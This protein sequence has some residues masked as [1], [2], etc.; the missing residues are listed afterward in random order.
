MVLVDASVS[1]SSSDYPSGFD[2]DVKPPQES[3]DIDIGSLPRPMPIFGPLFGFNN[4]HLARAIRVSI[5]RQFGPLHRMPTPDEAN[6]VAYHTA[7]GQA[8][9]S[10]GAPLGL[11]AGAYRTWATRASYKFPFVKAKE[12]FDANYM[13]WRGIVLAHGQRARFL[14]HSARFGAYGIIGLYVVKTAFLGFAASVA[15][16]GTLS[17]PRLADVVQALSTDRKAKLERE[18]V[19][20]GQQDPTGQGPTNASDLWKKHR[21][22]IGAPEVD[23]GGPTAGQGDFAESQATEAKMYGDD[24]NMGNGQQD[25]APVAQKASRPRRGPAWNRATTTPDPNT[26]SSPSDGFYGEY[27][28]AS[29]TASNESV[30]GAKTSSWEQLR[31]NAGINKSGS[32]NSGRARGRPAP[33]VVRE[34]DAPSGDSYSFSSSDEE[35]QL[36]R[37]Q[38]QRDFDAQ[39]ERERQ[40]GDFQSSNRG[41]GW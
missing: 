16:V 10:W 34:A 9:F 33:Q 38:A 12:G 18:R 2:S 37:D 41:R 23:D 14:W 8:I 26:D 25:T 11:A 35:R 13:T 40:G 21:G 28:D 4:E 15:A 29:P 22:A 7:K 19:T 17:D 27:D 36:A 3:I 32:T 24:G 30:P 31:R 6:A 20:R 5:Q 39:V 1:T